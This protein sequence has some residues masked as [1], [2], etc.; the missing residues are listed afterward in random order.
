MNSYLQTL[1]SPIIHVTLQPPRNQALHTAFEPDLPQQGVVP[2][3]I[4]EE[5][6]VPSERRV[7]LAVFI[8]V[9]CDGPG[10]VVEVQ[11]EHHALADVNE[12]ADLAAAS[13]KC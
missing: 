4:E 13:K 1:P 3:L 5:L 9:G 11:E 7:D 2:L 6:M 10:A 8:E 12:E